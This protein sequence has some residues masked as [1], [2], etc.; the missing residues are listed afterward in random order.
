MSLDMNEFDR[1]RSDRLAYVDALRRNKGFE[2]GILK[3]LTQLYPDNAHFIYELLQN[4]EDANASRVRFKLSND[5][6]IFE[7]NGKR[8]FTA[9][10]VESITSIGDSTKAD[11]ETEIGKF[12]VGFKAVFAYTKT[13]EI[14]SGNYHFRITNLLVPELLETIYILSDE[15]QTAF[16]FPFNHLSKNAS[17]ATSEIALALSSLEDTTLLFLTNIYQID[18]ELHD[19]T[20][21]KLERI[22]PAD[23]VQSKILGKHIQVF[24]QTP[25]VTFVNSNW[26]IYSKA[27]KI[28]KDIRKKNSSVS[29]AFRLK[30]ITKKKSNSLWEIIPLQPGRV[31][32]YFPAEKETSN[33]KFHIH[34]PFASTVARDSVRSCTGNTELLETI[35]QLT[36]E[37]ML[38][39]REKNLLTLSALEVLPIEDDNL[40]SFYEPIRQKLIAIFSEKD[41]VPTKN[42]TYRAAKDL[43]R[44][45]SEISKILDDQDLVML[46]RKNLT[47]PLWC[48]QPPVSNKRSNDFLNSLSIDSWSWNEL[49]DA[50]DCSWIQ[51]NYRDKNRLPRLNSWL[52]SKQD[53]WLKN[54][55]ELLFEATW[56][57]HK[58]FDF[59]ELSFVRTNQNSDDY[60]VKPCEVFF[61]NEEDEIRDDLQWVKKETYSSDNVSDKSEN[62]KKFL[63]NCGVKLFNEKE[64][65]ILI[66][67]DYKK[68]PF[69]RDKEHI[70][71]IKRFIEF[72]KKQPRESRAVFN[73]E[74]LI[75][76]QN[77]TRE[78]GFHTASNLILDSPFLKTGLATIEI[79]K[80]KKTLWQGYLSIGPDFI[81][82]VKALGVQSELI[83]SKTNVEENPNWDYL[84]IDYVYGVRMSSNSINADWSIDGLISLLKNPT[85]DSSSLIWRALIN[86]NSLMATARFR[87][88]ASCTTRESESQLV[89]LLKEFPW[90]PDVSGKFH[91]PSE[92]SRSQL[93]EDFPYDNRNGLLDAI[94]LEKNLQ[95]ITEEFQKIDKSAKELGFSGVNEARDLAKAAKEAGLDTATLIQ[96][97][98]QHSK[99]PE[100]PE[101]SVRNHERRRSGV[102][103]HRENAPPK[104]SVL[105]ERSI[106]PNIQTVV[107]QGKAYLRAKYTN[108]HGQM[109]CQ[110]CRQEMPFMLKTGEYYFEA[111]QVIQKL[112]QHYYENR[113][114]LCPVCAAKYLHARQEE[115]AQLKLQISQIDS[116]SIGNSVE[117]NVTLAGFQSTIRFTGTHFFDLKILIQ[118]S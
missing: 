111:I 110:A 83:I 89:W 37:S 71:H 48:A 4:A 109:I 41:L 36:A 65:L 6:L 115:D 66:L 54:L 32:I 5:S 74:F 30:E 100:L 39:L 118:N 73:T 15:F 28:G 102:L 79:V 69:P 61:P 10:D 114:A 107:A 53:G 26:L 116:K 40:S 87:P 62:A 20:H 72:Q 88:N 78:A 84:S 101:E 50:L 29:I 90:V 8:L 47:P 3:L 82:F 108:N 99:P 33:L 21:G 34:A 35:S 59:E 106:Q 117:L 98:K 64:A 13:P 85:I 19:G 31:S 56:H 91:L 1:L 105:R 95:R 9:R 75:G 42:G 46:T 18:Y 55:Y 11:S 96:L 23:K 63:E 49:E 24:V 25:T 27:I 70:S 57:H 2:E 80:K 43:F 92:I 44:G 16:R 104:E 86:A 81:D 51:I 58:S 94:D 76:E 12:G 77:N 67:S 113:L 97:I 22:T 93:R 60:M 14:H 103:E 52:G 38:D 17:Q 45:P 68:E 7:H 112:E